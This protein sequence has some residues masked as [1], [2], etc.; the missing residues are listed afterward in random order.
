[1]GDA[2]CIVGSSEYRGRWRIAAGDPHLRRVDRP[3]CSVRQA[4]GASLGHADRHAAAHFYA[5]LHAGD[6]ADGDRN[7]HINTG[8][9]THGHLD[10]A[11]HAHSLAQ[12]YADTLPAGD[13]DA[14]PHVH[15]HAGAYT[16]TAA[17]FHSHAAPDTHAARQP[18]TYLHGDAEP[19]VYLDPAAQR[20]VYGV[21]HS[22]PNADRAG[23]SHPCTD[24]GYR[25]SGAH[26]QPQRYPVAQPS[27]DSH[28]DGDPH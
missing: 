4:N 26:S 25:R 11:A 23:F 1:V 24:G 19:D 10:S 5:D 9:A 12:R 16:D 20:D 21:A 18:N 15:P 28:P 6:M 3:G 8:S 22:N 17:D 13:G 14:N 2:D 7:E 27:A